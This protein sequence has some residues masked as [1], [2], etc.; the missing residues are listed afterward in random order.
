LWS[1]DIPA[2]LEDM[3]AHLTGKER[4]AFTRNKRVA[5]DLM[6]SLFPPDEES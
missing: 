5:A 4:T 3:P 6:K 1:P 2:L